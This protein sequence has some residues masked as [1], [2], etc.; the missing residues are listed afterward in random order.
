MKTAG[1]NPEVEDG[2]DPDQTDGPEAGHRDV[3]GADKEIR[4]WTTGIKAMAEI[5]L[6]IERTQESEIEKG[7][8]GVKEI[9]EKDNAMEKTREV[10]QSPESKIRV[11]IEIIGKV[12]L[13]MT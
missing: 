12:Q 9:L 5:T 13:I 8:G 11:I 2:E 1:L 3:P 7:V 4:L 6:V 10:Q